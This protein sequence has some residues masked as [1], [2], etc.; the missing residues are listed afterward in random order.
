MI[1]LK[2]AEHDFQRCNSCRKKMV[3]CITIKPEDSTSSQSYY[4]CD[5][6]LLL[7]VKKI[8]EFKNY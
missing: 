2:K 7:M 5:D 8:S 3:T 6:C 4:L 1:I